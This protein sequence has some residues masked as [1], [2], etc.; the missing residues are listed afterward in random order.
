MRKER[1]PYEDDKAKTKLTE[2]KTKG[3]E[4]CLETCDDGEEEGKAKSF[5]N[6]WER[7][8]KVVR[9]LSFCLFRKLNIM[10]SYIGT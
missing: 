4:D 9:Q 3:L 10:L 6:P 5:T 2:R 8:G 7:K 1:K